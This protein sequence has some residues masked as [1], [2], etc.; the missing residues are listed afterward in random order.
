[1]LLVNARAPILEQVGLSVQQIDSAQLEFQY[2]SVSGA[3][4]EEIDQVKTVRSYLSEKAT[5]DIPIPDGH[6][7]LHVGLYYKL[8]TLENTRYTPTPEPSLQ[9]PVITN[10]M[11]SEITVDLVHNS[12]LYH[13]TETFHPCVPI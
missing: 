5:Y 1:M 9:F 8:V 2:Q 6:P 12:T 4:Y 13:V 7:S 10:K 11:S 3:G